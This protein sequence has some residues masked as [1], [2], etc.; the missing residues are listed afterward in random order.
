MG[1]LPG[2][3]SFED[4]HRRPLHPL[5]SSSQWRQELLAAGFQDFVSFTEPGSAAEV[6]GVGVML[7]RLP[8]GA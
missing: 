8:G 3:D 1:F 7:A 4:Y 2:F 5:L 6:V